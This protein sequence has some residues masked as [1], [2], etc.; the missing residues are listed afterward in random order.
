MLGAAS[1]VDLQV[2]VNHLKFSAHMEKDHIVKAM[3]SNKP[4]DQNLFFCQV[5][6]CNSFESNQS[7]RSVLK[8]ITILN[9]FW[10]S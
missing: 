7:I 6:V 4:V 10:H 8:S 1:C 3:G 5:K 9:I 2:A